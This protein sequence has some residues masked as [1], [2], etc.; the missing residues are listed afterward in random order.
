MKSVSSRP[1]EDW[2]R[3]RFDAFICGLASDS[4]MRL[5]VIEIESLTTEVTEGEDSILTSGPT[6]P[7]PP[8]HRFAIRC[9]FSLK[10]ERCFRRSVY[11]PGFAAVPFV[12]R[13]A[14]ASILRDRC[15]QRLPFNCI[16]FQLWAICLFHCSSSILSSRSNGTVRTPPHAHVIDPPAIDGRTESAFPHS[17]CSCGNDSDPKSVSAEV[18]A[19]DFCQTVARRTK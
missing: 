3:R 2:L 12:F 9:C 5:V 16:R 4:E 14:A 10:D 19:I 8:V 13:L 7:S 1:T 15:R 6:A 18:D 11:R 17:H